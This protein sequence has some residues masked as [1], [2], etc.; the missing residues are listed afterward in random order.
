MSVRHKTFDKHNTVE[1]NGSSLIRFGEKIH[2]HRDYFDA[3][4]LIYERVPVLG[5]VIQSIKARL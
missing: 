4:A 1:V 3:G 2:F 5:K